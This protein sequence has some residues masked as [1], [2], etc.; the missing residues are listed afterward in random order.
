MI[1]A[2]KFSLGL[3]TQKKRK[4]NKGVVLIAA[5]TIC[6]IGTGGTVN[7][8]R[9][10]ND[11]KNISKADV[12]R[13]DG[14]QQ[15]INKLNATGNHEES[16]AYADKYINNATNA[17][18][19]IYMQVVKGSIYEEQNNLQAA[20]K[21]YREIEKTAG[22][23]IYGVCMGIARTSQKLGD[24]QTAIEYYKKAIVLAKRS[25]SLA[26]KME[27]MDLESRIKAL[28]EGN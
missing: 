2:S 8:L 26:N 20:L 22:R 27:V 14:V 9:H 6:L 28:E 18:D 15:S 16:L 1:R 12:T 13:R 5:L 19:K 3:T 21:Q 4:I 17:E 10:R 24:K 23:D 11:Q 25:D 7:W